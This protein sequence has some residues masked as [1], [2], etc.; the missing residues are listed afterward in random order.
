[1][2]G[3][4]NILCGLVVSL[5]LSVFAAEKPEDAQRTALAVE[6]LSRMQG[7]D[8]E[9]N[10]KLKEA[11]L[12]VLERTRGTPDFVKIVQQFKIKGQEPGLLEVAVKNP[13]SEEGVEAMRLLLAGRNEAPLQNA[14]QSTNGDTAVRTAEALGNAGATD[15]SLKLL[16]PII[17]DSK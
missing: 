13:S 3:I 4:Q 11:V 14:L 9:Q 10:S 15:L 12:K 1:M 6:A 7:V 2:T 5:C 16:L 17:K 8:L